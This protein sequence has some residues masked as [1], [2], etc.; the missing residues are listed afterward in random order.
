MRPMWRDVTSLCFEDNLSCFV[1]GLKKIIG[2]RDATSFW[3][4]DG[5]GSGK[6]ER[7]FHRL[8]NFSRKKY[9]SIK[10]LGLWR[11]GVWC[12]AFNLRRG[13]RGREVV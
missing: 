1:S 6:L 4:E 9:S 2:E 3:L 10:D 5:L 11:D 8:Y 7:Q 12:W 13:L